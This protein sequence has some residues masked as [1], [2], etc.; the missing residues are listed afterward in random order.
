MQQESI[1]E[2]SRCLNEPLNIQVPVPKVLFSSH[3]QCKS[4]DPSTITENI[5]LLIQASTS[6]LWALC[7]DACFGGD[8]FSVSSTCPWYFLGKFFHSYSLLQVF[9]CIYVYTHLTPLNCFSF[10]T[11]EIFI[12]SKQNSIGIESLLSFLL[13]TFDMRKTLHIY[14]PQLFLF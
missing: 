6:L 4:E 10:R 12:G 9:I 7:S 11:A 14:P 13:S 5:H 1:N 8:F 2:T 3:C